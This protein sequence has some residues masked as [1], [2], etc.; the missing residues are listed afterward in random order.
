[1]CCCTAQ[2]V[3]KLDILCADPNTV[4][5]LDS[6]LKADA[7]IGVHVAVP[8]VIYHDYDSMWGAS[9]M[10]DHISAVQI[11]SMETQDIIGLMLYNGMLDFAILF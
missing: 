11:F 6:S 8:H 7:I 1:M 9:V 5:R 3:K 10:M 4:N 2:Q